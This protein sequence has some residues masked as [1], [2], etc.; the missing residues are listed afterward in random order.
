[1]KQHSKKILEVSP[2]LSWSWKKMVPRLWL[3]WFSKLWTE[4]VCYR[5]F[6]IIVFWKKVGLWTL[7]TFCYRKCMLP[8]QY[9]SAWCLHGICLTDIP[10]EKCLKLSDHLIQIWSP[11]ANLS[12][13]QRFGFFWTPATKTTFIQELAGRFRP[14]FSSDAQS[15]AFAKKSRSCTQILDITVRP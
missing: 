14:R 6:E 3:L 8:L 9:L 12:A 5:Y 15:R 4:E 10:E 13:L 2:P 1:M 11:L 7:I